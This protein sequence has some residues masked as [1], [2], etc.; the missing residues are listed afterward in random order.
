ML[1]RDSN[2]QGNNNIN[3]ISTIIILTVSF[4]II[5]LFLLFHLL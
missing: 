1:M 5:Y 2:I 4:F 3:Y